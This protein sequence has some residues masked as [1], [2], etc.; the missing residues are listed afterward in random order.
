MEI[1]PIM[2]IQE[3]DIMSLQKVTTPS[4]LPA[5]VLRN[6]VLYPG[7]FSPISVNRPK[8]IEALKTAYEQDKVIVALIQKQAKIDNPT[9]VDIE[10]ICTVAKIIKLITMPDNSITAIVQGIKRAE[11]VKI[12]DTEPFFKAEVEVLKEQNFSTSKETKALIGNIRDI[13]E[14]IVR[15]SPSFPEEIIVLIKNIEDALFFTYFIASHFP[16]AFQDKLDL[17]KTNEPKKRAEKLVELLHKEYQFTNLKN[18]VVNKTRS[19]IDKQQKEYFLQQQLQSIK[20]ELGDGN[21]K[22]VQELKKQAENKKWPKVAKDL[23]DKNI[24]KLE[25]M[26]PS[27]PDYSVVYN[28]TELLLDLP[29]EESVKED[30]DIQEAK[31]IL[32]FDHYGMQKAKQRILEYLAVLKIKGDMKSPILCFVGPPGVGKTSLGKSIAHAMNRKYIRMSL[33]GLHDE[34]EIRGHRKTYIGAMPGR[35][36]QAI[37]KVK[38]SQPVIVLDELDKLGSD[39]R[40]DPA[41]ALLEV[42]D[43]EQNNS[44][45]DNYLEVEYDLSKVLFIATANNLQTIPAPLRDRLEIIDLT[46]YAT[47][48]KVKIAEKHLIQKQQV[49]HGMEKLKFTI[50]EKLLTIMIYDYT[51]ESGVREL[52]RLIASIL[53]HRALQ[54]TLKQKLL[55]ILTEKE[56]RAILGKPKYSNDKY[57]KINPPGVV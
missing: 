40:G 22:E 8:S 3:M 25:R 20:E 44:F 21:D 30:Y 55:T 2:P 15:E 16:L 19:E 31:K 46:G 54:Y 53:R 7:V 50:P 6:S 41:S 45:Y 57:K 35:I 27:T 47:E 10:K 37:R 26:H 13:T 34:S 18:Q 49:A 51:R 1:L 32:D 17:L 48:E 4:L 12:T 28:H 43:P 36:I 9:E 14:K 38:S 39:F 56:L 23:F 24:E 42:L 5:L 11:W 52:D 33:G 29:W